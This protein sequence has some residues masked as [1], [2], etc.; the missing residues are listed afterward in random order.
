RL[1]C[2]GLQVD[3]VEIKPFTAVKEG[4]TPEHQVEAIKHIVKRAAKSIFDPNPAEAPSY[5]TLEPSGKK[6]D[7]PITRLAWSK[8]SSFL[9]ALA[10][11]KDSVHITVWD[12]KS[13]E[14]IPKQTGDMSVLH[15]SFVTADVTQ[16]ISVPGEIFK[17]LSI[18]LAISPKGDKV[19]IYQEPNV[20]QW[21]DGSKLEKSSFRIRVFNNPLVRRPKQ[22]ERRQ[23]PKSGIY[24]LA[25]DGIEHDGTQLVPQE[26]IP[27]RIFDSF[28]GYGA[29]LTEKVNT[30]WERNSVSAALCNT[31]SVES[32]G[33]S[34]YVTPVNQKGPL[35]QDTTLFVACNGLCIDVFRI[36]T[37]N[38]WTH[39][40]TIRLTDL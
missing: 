20:G 40:R 14:S 39:V 12:M 22:P 4:N 17:N 33:S 5:W 13:I 28:I 30:D 24:T 3:F 26:T 27:H 1:E 29:F 32:L 19:A 18:G 15:P 10:V 7:I 16:K 38:A 36:V 6:A 2:S 21:K 8:D 37:E 35:K 31:P 25:V 11:K 9:V 34:L 23:E